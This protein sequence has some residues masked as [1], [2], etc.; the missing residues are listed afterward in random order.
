MADV[1]RQFVSD[2]YHSEKW[3]AKVAKM[4]DEQVVA[5]FLRQKAK[6]PEP[7]EESPDEPIP[8]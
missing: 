5:I 7:K 2:M 1:E 8:F 4:S 6:Q 3:K